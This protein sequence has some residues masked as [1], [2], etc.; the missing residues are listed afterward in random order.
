P[1]TAVDFARDIKPIFAKRCVSCHGPDTAEASLRLDNKRDALRGGNSG[2]ALLAGEGD[3]SRLV[4]YVA[5]TAEDETIMPPE[6]ERLLETEVALI[7][8]WVNQGVKWPDEPPGAR[9]HSDLWSLQPIARPKPPAVKQAD[10]VRNPIDRFV[11]AKLE[12]EGIAPS[13]EADPATLC[14]RLYLDLTGLPPKP[15][16]VDEFV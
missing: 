14:R 2:A 12:A 13:P 16:E 6:G 1:S 15:E 7:R 4:Q 11:L 5:G 3:K 8:A 10:W 9:P